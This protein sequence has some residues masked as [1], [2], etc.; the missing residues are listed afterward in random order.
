VSTRDVPA[1][2]LARQWLGDRNLKSGTS[3][4]CNHITEADIQSLT[5]LIERVRRDTLRE[6]P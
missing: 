3:K 4:R 6:E 2:Q 1:E 5:A